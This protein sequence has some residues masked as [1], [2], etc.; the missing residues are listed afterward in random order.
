[1]IRT[2]EQ[3]IDCLAEDM[4]WRRKELTELK[5][6]I[7]RENEGVRSRV[8]IRSAIALLYAHWEGFVKKA[9][10]CYLEY[11][12]SRRL[13]MKDL[14]PGF[15]GLVVRAKI[16]EIGES[17][18]VSSGI[19]LAE[20]FIGSMDK[21]IKIP[22]KA[23]VDTKSNLTSKV[24]EDILSSL[25]LDASF[26]STK[27]NLID[28]NLVNKRNHVAHGEALSLTISEYLDLH[29]EVIALIESFKNE[30]ENAS[31]QNKFKCCS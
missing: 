20:F 12:A 15:I 14:S 28:A 22:Y 23:G 18:K 30:I 5:A 4:I 7:E 16:A 19:S 26:F 21:Q 3:L 29:G 11:V 10:R 8:L 31:V 27:S 1:M 13:K 25:S 17:E 9:S 24:L 6:L 2:S